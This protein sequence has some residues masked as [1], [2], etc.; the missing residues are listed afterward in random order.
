MHHV[1]QR[2]CVWAQA[3]LQD[4]APP[5]LNVQTVP[6]RAA[7]EDRLDDFDV[8]A[9]LAGPRVWVIRVRC[10]LLRCIRQSRPC[11]AMV[12]A[13]T[14]MVHSPLRWY[15]PLMGVVAKST[16]HE[17]CCHTAEALLLISICLHVQG[18]AIER[19]AQMT[20]WNYYEAARRFQ[21]VGRRPWK[22]FL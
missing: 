19:F 14:A 10:W 3:A 4:G 15:A 9:D 7:S 8:E 6:G 22:R 13:R 1:Q 21:K 5:A 2:A 16:A 20:N 17:R 12:H 11:S 18:K